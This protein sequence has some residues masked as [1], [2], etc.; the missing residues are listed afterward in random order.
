MFHTDAGSH[1]M[2]P[3]SIRSF[4]FSARCLAVNSHG[5]PLHQIGLFGATHPFGDIAGVKAAVSPGP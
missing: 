1:P 4:Q 2:S 3:H 5:V